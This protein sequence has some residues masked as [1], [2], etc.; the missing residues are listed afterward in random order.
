MVLALLATRVRTQCTVPEQE[1]SS[2]SLTIVILSEVSALAR[3]R[4]D[5]VEEPAPSEVEETL[6]AAL[7]PAVG[8]LRLRRNFAKRSFPSAQDDNELSCDQ[9][10]SKKNAPSVAV[11]AADG[12]PSAK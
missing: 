11:H 10:S 8:V 5:V 2:E 3:E 4:T 6:A 12:A 9:V 1:L 7:L